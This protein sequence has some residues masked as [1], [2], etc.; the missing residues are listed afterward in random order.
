MW[1]LADDPEVCGGF[2]GAYAWQNFVGKPEH[3]VHIGA[4]VHLAA[5]DQG[6]RGHF[7]RGSAAVGRK[8]LQ[9]H[10]VGH[11]GDGDVGPQAAQGVGIGWRDGD[12]A[13]G[14]AAEG[15]FVRGQFAPLHQGVGRAGPTRGVAQ[16]GQGGA[17]L[18]DGLG[19]VIVEDQA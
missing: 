15:G 1:L 13:V 5:E 16:I 17:L 14:Q 9:I 7:R 8:G 3:G 4:V 6:R 11:D 18:Q 12:D 10:A 2:T 19:V